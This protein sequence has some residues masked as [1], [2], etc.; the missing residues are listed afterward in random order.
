MN[1]NLKDIF[2]FLLFIVL[3]LFVV[4]HFI[5]FGK[6]DSYKVL[7]VVYGD[8]FYID[9]NNDGKKDENELVKLDLV[10]TFSD[11]QEQN[12]NYI[13]KIYSITNSEAEYL[14]KLAKQYSSEKLKNQIV[15]VKNLK[16]G[17]KNFY[18]TI[19][20][21]NKDFAETLLSEGLAYSYNPQHFDYY[22]KFENKIF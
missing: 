10:K 1:K 14:G 16:K 18:A 8:T 15:L 5:D 19:Y 12:S 6:S 22:I 9:L 2:K 7:E 4:F 20:L 21:N 17:R 13:L 11:V 3:S